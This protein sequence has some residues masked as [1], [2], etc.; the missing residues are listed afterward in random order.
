MAATQLAC[1]LS[2]VVDCPLARLELFE[3]AAALAAH[4][5]ASVAVV[6]CRCSDEAAWRARLERRAVQDSGS[7]R[8]HRPGSWEKLQSVVEG[9]QGCCGWSTDG[10]VTLPCHIC[11]DTAGA[12][13]AEAVSELAREVVLPV[14]AGLGLGARCQMPIDATK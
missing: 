9:Y 3:R 8:A 7:C 12:L 1:G 14:L 4:H 11:V 13:S 5:G 10:S 6:E 2:V